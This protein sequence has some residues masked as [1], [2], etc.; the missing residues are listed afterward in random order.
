MFAIYGRHLLEAGLSEKSRADFSTETSLAESLSDRSDTL[1]GPTGSISNAGRV[2][3]GRRITAL[4]VPLWSFSRSTPSV[5]RAPTARPL[6]RSPSGLA[7]DQYL[8]GLDTAYS[9]GLT[10][11]LPKSCQVRLA[12]GKTEILVTRRVLHHENLLVKRHRLTGWIESQ[13]I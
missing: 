1:A 12:S 2:G 9:A 7:P 11:L 10:K 8:S 13:L 4:S 3:P 6:S 5:S